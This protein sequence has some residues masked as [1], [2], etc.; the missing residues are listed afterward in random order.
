MKKILINYNGKTIFAFVV[1]DYKVTISQED[2][3]KDS[4]VVQMFTNGETID[5]IELD[6]CKEC[7]KWCSED[8]GLYG[9]G[10]CDSCAVLCFDCEVYFN[11]K[12]MHSISNEEMICQECVKK[13]Q[14]SNDLWEEFGDIPIN[15]DEEIDIDWRE[16]KKGTPRE[17]IWHWFEEKYDLSVA[18]DL[19]GV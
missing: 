14:E 17:D 13:R 16:F 7:G 6:Q 11:H 18:K 4:S 8:D 2:A 12:T 15:K 5:C 1:G 9:D 3:E 10:I 19:M